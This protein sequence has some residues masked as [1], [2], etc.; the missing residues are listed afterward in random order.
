MYN[1]IHSTTTKKVIYQNTLKTLL[2]HKKNFEKYFVT[3]RKTVKGNKNSEQR[4]NTKQKGTL[5]L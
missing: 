3:H 4:E 2:I 5:K 1:V